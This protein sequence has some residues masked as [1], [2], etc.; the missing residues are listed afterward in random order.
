MAL[1][2]ITNLATRKHAVSRSICPENPTGGKGKG[3]MAEIAEGDSGHPARDLGKGWKVSPCISIPAH[4]TV[5]IASI[6]EPGCINHIWVTLT[7]TWRSTILRAY[8]DD[9]EKPSIES[10][11]GDF[12]CSGWNRYSQVSSLAVC[13]NP[14]NG[15]KSISQNSE[16]APKKSW[17]ML[18][19]RIFS[20]PRI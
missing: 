4:T 14:A 8:W 10:P 6:S 19:R 16:M 20:A 15:F 3:A 13:V 17:R 7:G 9:E 11:V 1:G 2:D 12:F 5:T 18:Q